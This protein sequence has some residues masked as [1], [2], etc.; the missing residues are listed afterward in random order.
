MNIDREL[1]RRMD[2]KTCKRDMRLVGSDAK[3]VMHADRLTIGRK[4]TLLK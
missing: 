3:A 2:T 1:Y 4:A